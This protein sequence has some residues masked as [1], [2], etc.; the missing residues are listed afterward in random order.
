MID[1]DL[2]VLGSVTADRLNIGDTS[3]SA[4][5]SG[6]LLV[7]GGNITALQDNFYTAATPL[8]GSGFSS[9]PVKADLSLVGGNTI[10]V[11]PGFTADLQLVVT[12]EHGYFNL[13]GFNDD[14]G[15]YIEGAFAGAS[16]PFPVLY[17]RYDP[18]MTLETDYAT[19]AVVEKNLT[20]PSAT[21]YTNYNVFV[22]WG[23]GSADIQLLRCLTS[24]FVRF[25]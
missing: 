13:P 8:S 1:G 23:G 24:V 14:W 6:G 3:L 15:L 11:P 12:F 7:R 20:N 19:V 9:P 2:L 10:S 4:D 18:T 17:E 22:F 16:P 21:A 5:A 25:K